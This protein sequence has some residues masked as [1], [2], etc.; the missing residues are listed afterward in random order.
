MQWRSGPSGGGVQKF[1]GTTPCSLPRDVSSGGTGSRT[2]TVW[3]APFGRAHNGT[4]PDNGA[5]AG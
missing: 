3:T 5:N 4:N 1:R 2:E